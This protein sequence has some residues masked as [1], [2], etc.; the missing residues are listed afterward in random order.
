[1]QLTRKCN[2]PQKLAGSINGNYLVIAGS[3]IRT[4]RTQTIFVSPTLSIRQNE[5]MNCSLE[6]TSTKPHLPPNLSIP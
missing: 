2:S 6:V 5:Q 1:M 4:E 3:P